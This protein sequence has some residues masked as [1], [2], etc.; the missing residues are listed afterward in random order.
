MCEIQFIKPLKEK[1]KTQDIDEFITML[2]V[3]SFSNPHAFGLTNGEIIFK[4]KGLV[5]LKGF[6]L[7]VL[8]NSTFLLGHNRYKTTGNAEN[9]FNNHPFKLKNFVLV[10]NG[11]ISNDTDLREKFKIESKE[12]T[13]SYV[14]LWLI[15][16]YYKK[17]TKKTHFKRVI[18]GIKK[19]ASKLEGSFSVFLYD[20]SEKN[21][22]Y[23]K[24]S[25]TNFIF[26]EHKDKE[27]HVLIGTTD[28]DKLNYLYMEEGYIINEKARTEY[29]ILDNHIYLINDDEILKDCGKFKAKKSNFT[30]YNYGQYTEQDFKDSY[31]WENYGR[32]EAKEDYT[33]NEILRNH[34]GHLPKYKII[35]NKGLIKIK[36]DVRLCNEVFKEIATLKDDGYLYIDIDELINFDYNYFENGS[37]T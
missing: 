29:E 10:H 36:T 20:K 16:Y 23:F 13:D 2:Q 11:I 35:D 34:I 25:D 32:T 1:I 3:G 37:Y 22:F 12:K 18:E 8:R 33:I 7:N 24:N 21:L 26:L 31:S 9:N 14:I 30:S 15:D 17:S 27:K 28:Q 5:N 6:N 4:R 19:T